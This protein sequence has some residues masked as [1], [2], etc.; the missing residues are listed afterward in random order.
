MTPEH[1][2]DELIKRIRA[3]IHGDHDI[4]KDCDDEASYEEMIPAIYWPS[5]WLIEAIRAAQAE[6][7]EAAYTQGRDDGYDL[8]IYDKAGDY[9]EGL[10]DNDFREQQKKESLAI[11]AQEDKPGDLGAL[12]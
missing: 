10:T 3:S 12:G 11:L 2:K 1:H 4:N 7:R 8:H 5:R 9:P 6:A